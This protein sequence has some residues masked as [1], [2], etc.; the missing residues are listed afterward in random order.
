MPFIIVIIGIIVA[1]YFWAQRAR[2]AAEIAKAVAEV[3]GDIK[4]AA[5]RRAAADAYA[6]GAV[7][8]GGFIR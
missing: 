1:G 6:S 7:C 3:P 2:D 8:A 4:A 5:D